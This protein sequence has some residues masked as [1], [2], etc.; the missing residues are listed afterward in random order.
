MLDNTLLKKIIKVREYFEDDLSKE[1]LNVKLNSLVEGNSKVFV[2]WCLNNDYK[3]RIPEL[4]KYEK[5]NGFGNEYAIFG[6][7][8][9]GLFAAKSLIL[10]KRK[11]IAIVDN[12][13]RLWGNK[14][15]Y[16]IPV[17]SP[18]E[19]KEK[20]ENTPIIVTPAM[21]VVE[22]YKQ[23]LLLRVDRRL[24]FLPECGFLLGHLGNQYFDFFEPN[25]D[26]VFVDAGSFDGDTIIDFVKWCGLKD[27]Q[28]IYAFEPD[29][30]CYKKCLKT[31]KDNK[32]KNVTCIPKATWDSVGEYMMNSNGYGSSSV[33]GEGGDGD[34]TKTTT[35]DEECKNSKVTFIKLDVE[36]SEIRTLIGAQNTIKRCKPRL[37]ISVYHKPNDIWEIADYIKQLVP[38][39]NMALRHYTNYSWET[40]LYCY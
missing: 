19:Y 3:L 14:T 30:N 20:W 27:Y 1:I 37:A 17:I 31:T 40:I 34:V 8:N 28:A 18:Y 24:I 10:S 21:G 33:K 38:E 29:E 4:D 36:G 11:P 12:N 39:Y 2:D 32:V 23:L 6:A 16:D 5:S 25:D 9:N 15:I 13:K 26:E 35:I 7:G 22:I